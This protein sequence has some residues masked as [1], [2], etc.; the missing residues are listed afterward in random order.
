VGQVIF[1]DWMGFAAA[2]FLMDLLS[3]PNARPPTILIDELDAGRLKRV[4]N[5]QIIRRRHGGLLMDSTLRH[6]DIDA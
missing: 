6:C 4:A 1:G 2:L 5:C 3:E